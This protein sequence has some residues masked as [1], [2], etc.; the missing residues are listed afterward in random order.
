MILNGSGLGDEAEFPHTGYGRRG[1][2]TNSRE[3]D[4]FFCDVRVMWEL[5]KDRMTRSL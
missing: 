5:L 4:K 2:R 1:R 3:E